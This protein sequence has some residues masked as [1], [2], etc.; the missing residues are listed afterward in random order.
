[1]VRKRMS[2]ERTTSRGN[3]KDEMDLR[4]VIPALH[5]IHVKALGLVGHSKGSEYIL[6]LEIWYD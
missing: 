1:M 6:M 4:S 2:I 5:A 3:S